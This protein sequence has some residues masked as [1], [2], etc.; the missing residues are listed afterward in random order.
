MRVFL[1]YASE[2]RVR[3]EEIAL[4]LKGRGH[5]V[6]LDADVLRG[7]ED[8]NRVIHAEIDRADRFLFL[9]SP[10]AIDP[11]S[12]TLTELRMAQKRWPH[13]GRRVL[14]VMLEPTELERV[15][16]YLRAVTIFQPAGNVA[17]ELAAHLPPRRRWSR[18]A[19]LGGLGVAATALAVIV[20]MRPFGAHEAP[21]FKNRI[22]ESDF[23]TRYVL[24]PD[25]VKRA[26]YT[27]DP[28]APFPADRGDVVSVARIAHGTL[29]ERAL[30]WNIRVRLTNPTDRPIQLDLNPRFFELG[31]DR[32]RKAELQFFCCEAH[33]ELLGPGQ[34]R[35]LQLIYLSPPGWAGKETSAGMIS[36]HVSGL[37]PLARGTWQFRPLAT[38][39]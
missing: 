16:A 5:D 36:F 18:A 19:L 7:G 10:H 2:N 21:R 13:P 4:A 17:A 3:A 6:F 32:G 30:G 20:T 35:E 23:V 25:L 26:E 27:L 24:P 34:H 12:Y 14:P 1:S 15:P 29:A 31:D 11:G 9:I 33:A 28:T 39:N 22:A 38:A 37:I 8:Y